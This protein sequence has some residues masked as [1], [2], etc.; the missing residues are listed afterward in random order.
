M[1][2]RKVYVRLKP[3]ALQQFVRVTETEILPWLR[4]QEGFIDLI[5]LAAPDGGEVQALSF[6]NHH[7]NAQANNCTGYPEG[8]LRRLESLLDGGA[9][10]KTFQVVSSTL[11]KFAPIPRQELESGAPEC[12]TFPDALGPSF[13][14]D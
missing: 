4:T 12:V 14:A 2:A 13:S 10:G 8:I 9:Y 11:E 6:W 3:H 1:F 5:I 7:G